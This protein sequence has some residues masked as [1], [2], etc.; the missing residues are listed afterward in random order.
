MKKYAATL[1][2]ALMVLL[3]LTALAPSA[4][5]Y[6]TPVLTLK[7]S[8]QSV[9]SGHTFNAVAK[10]SVNCD[11]LT[12]S[13]SGQ[14]ATAP[15]ST[16]THT[17]RAPI[18]TVPTVITAVAVCRYSSTTGTA[19]AAIAATE[20]SLTAKANITVLPLT[21]AGSGHLPNTGGPSIGWL[22][23]GIAALLAGAVAMFAGR[24][25]SA[26]VVSH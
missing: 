18:V 21:S 20:Q 11:T 7:L 3:G 23:A 19:G 8:V 12:V 25:R 14:S 1:A 15:G 26:G 6:P 13:W 9:I 22:I 2:A 24:R 16:L 10:A 5:A 4:E 17:F